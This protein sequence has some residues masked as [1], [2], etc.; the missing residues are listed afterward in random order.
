MKFLEWTY[1]M[2]DI[3]EEKK[4]RRRVSWMLGNFLAR[5]CDDG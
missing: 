5:V 4:E 3:Y 2:R 1:S